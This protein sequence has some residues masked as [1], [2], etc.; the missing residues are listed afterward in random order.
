MGSHTLYDEGID[1]ALDL[2]Q[3]TCHLNALVVSAFGGGWRHG[4]GW[5]IQKRAD[6]G[7]PIPDPPKHSPFAWVQ[8]HEEHYRGIRQRIPHDPESDYGDR[9][10]LDDCAEP[11]AKRGIALYPRFFELRATH[12]SSADDWDE[13]DAEGRATGRK[14]LRNPD[15]NRF[16]HAVIEDLVVHHPYIQGAMYLQERH[17]PLDAVFGQKSNADHVGH[18]FCEHCCRAARER[19]LDPEK[20]KAAYRELTG[21]AMA[22]R[23]DAE[24]PSDGWFIN[25]IRLFTKFPELMAWQELF[26]D[27][28][29]RHRQGIYRAVKRI[30]PDLRMGWHLHHP[31]SFQLF[32]RAGMNFS[33][34]RHYSDWAKPNVYPAASGG[35]SRGSWCNGILNTLFKDVRPEIGIELMFDLLGYDAQQMPNVADYLSSENVPGWGAHYVSQE[36]KRALAGLAGIDVYPGLGF[37]L[38]AG[39]DTPESVRACTRAVFEAGAPGILLSREYEEMAVEHLKAVGAAMNDLG[40]TTATR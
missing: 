21:L 30:R 13:V 18:C 35:R 4:Q 38:P 10:I 31:M 24:R 23:E 26:W 3:D 7:R 29:H 40:L 1:H 19:G 36:T 25:F 2:L 27:G 39:G 20:A 22:A 8:T 16:S 12:A 17:G 37:D 5:P 15:W 6:H 14:C 9:D 11:A 34:V 32:Y 33:C 28:L